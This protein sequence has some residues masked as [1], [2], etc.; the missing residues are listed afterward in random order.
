MSNQ[1]LQKK[2]DEGL[3]DHPSWVGRHTT[4][5]HLRPM[6]AK[7]V[8]VHPELAPALRALKKDALDHLDTL[9]PQTIAAM[10]QNGFHVYVA[11]ESSQAADYIANIVGDHLV[12]KSKTNTGK[13]IGL[14]HRL[15]EQGATVYETDLGD[16]LAQLEGKGKASHTLAPASHLTRVECSQLLSKD[17]GEDLPTDPELLVG[18][19]RRSLRAAF[20]R[21]EV[22]ISGANAIAA[23]TG[24]IFLTE[25]EGNMCYQHS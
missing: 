4:I 19:A 11:E 21:A 24:A 6:I 12:V 8:A 20:L 15:Q 14:T 2:I 1:A 18:A 13:E 17:L 5:D 10:E 3:E 9:L 22:G 23:D 16:R 25:N 7:T